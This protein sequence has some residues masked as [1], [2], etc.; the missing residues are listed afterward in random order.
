MQP[1]I[2]PPRHVIARL[3]AFVLWLVAG[4]ALADETIADRFWITNGEV[5]AIEHA[6]GKVYLGGAFSAVGPAIGSAAVFDLGSGEAHTPYPEVNGTVKAVVADASG[7]YYLGGQFTRVRGIERLNLAHIDAAGQVTAWNPV[8]IGVV[9][10][11]ALSGSTVYIGGD[12]QSVGGAARS[13]LAAVDATTGAPTAWAPFPES[14]GVIHALLASATTLYVGGSFSRMNGVTVNSSA[15]FD[16]A[17]GATT[18]YYAPTSGGSV[19][20]FALR[21]NTLYLGGSFS[22][23][24]DEYRYRLA[25]VNATTGALLNWNP[26]VSQ[27]GLVG[28]LATTQ[29]TT[30]PFTVTVWVG[31]SFTAS[32]G[33]ARANLAAIDGST[34]VATA[35]NPGASGQVRSLQV[36]A[37]GATGEAVAIYAGGDFTTLGGANRNFLGAV[38]AAGVATS[39]AP[40]PNGLVRSIAYGPSGLHAGGDFYSAAMAPR[41]NFA[42]LDSVTGAAEAWNPGA[43]GPVNT[44]LRSGGSLYVGGA[45]SLV[46]GAYRRG[47]ARIDLDAQAVEPW[48][49]LLGCA[50]NCYDPSVHAI[51]LTADGTLVYLGGEFDV[52]GGLGRRNLASVDVATGAT[53]P[54]NVSTNGVVRSLALREEASFPFD[55]TVFAAGYFT[56]VNHGLFGYGPGGLAR[57][58][59]AAADGASGEATPWNPTRGTWSGVE[60]VRFTGGAAGSM[61]TVW[62][63]GSFHEVG[64]YVDPV[65][66]LN[67]AA[68]DGGTAVPTAW[69]PD[70]NGAIGSLLLANGRCYLGGSFSTLGGEPRTG[71]GS[72]DR[73]LGTAFAWDPNLA[74]GPPLAALHMSGGTVYA[75]GGFTS[76]SGTAHRYFAAIQDGSAL[77]S[78]EE[79][80]PLASERRLRVAPNPSFDRAAIEFSLRSAGTVEVSVFDLTGGLVRR[81]HRGPLQAGP[82]RLSWDGLD[83]TGGR[84]GSGAYFVQVRSPGGT[85]GTKVFRIR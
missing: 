25:A 84:A 66:R 14:P 41:E 59:L 54:F 29:R 15:A 7:G 27:F 81:L 49:P 60:V 28:A 37:S 50:G 61:G 5:R 26:G 85:A 67:A 77:V 12:F 55:V 39:W 48:N 62:V 35:W 21:G 16:L 4:P 80:P 83:D 70:P 68:F 46:G 45:F 57:Y 56:T 42:V 19:S 82:H 17:T 76:A 64:P 8:V 1:R 63:G 74:G 31:G 18:G 3:L 43:D 32:G 51:A 11:I 78:V 24:R 58:G 36:R 52:S 23:I 71:I 9:N 38:D 2:G 69:A 72:V 53:Y 34:G 40:E 33:A 13:S 73:E 22:T 79:R 20:A 47:V 65:A 30:S 44:L 6:D 10:A 75:G